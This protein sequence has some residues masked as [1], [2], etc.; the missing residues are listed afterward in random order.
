MAEYVIPVYVSFRP[1]MRRKGWQDAALAMA[2]HRPEDFLPQVKRACRD[3]FKA[4]LGLAYGHS[5]GTFGV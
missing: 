3:F 2:Y 1:A 5:F 4:G